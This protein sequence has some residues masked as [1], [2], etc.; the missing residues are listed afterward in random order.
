M[1]PSLNLLFNSRQSQTISKMFCLDHQ[2]LF[3]SC[4]VDA[5]SRDQPSMVPNKNKGKIVVISGFDSV[6][7]HG[8]QGCV[9]C[10]RTIREMDHN[11]GL[12]TSPTKKSN[13][14]ALDKDTKVLQWS[15]ESFQQSSETTAYPFATTTII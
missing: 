12:S 2:C 9:A 15:K 14:P 5:K 13:Q 3:K 10:E 4:Y 1:S 8:N 11:T 6:Q 7:S